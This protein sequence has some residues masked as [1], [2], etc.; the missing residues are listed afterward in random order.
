M[1]GY[2]PEESRMISQYPFLFEPILFRVPFFQRGFLLFFSL[3]LGFFLFL[4][5][6]GL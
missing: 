4:Q 5:Q 6:F 1:T 2:L 3:S